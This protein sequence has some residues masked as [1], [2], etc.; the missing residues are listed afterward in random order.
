MKIGSWNTAALFAAVRTKSM[1]VDMVSD[2]IPIV[3][4]IST[5]RPQDL[6][7][8]VAAYPALAA[9]FPAGLQDARCEALCQR[10]YVNSFL[11]HLFTF[12]DEAASHGFQILYERK[13]VQKQYTRALRHEGFRGS[14][15]GVRAGARLGGGMPLRRLS[16][17]ARACAR[18][19]AAEAADGRSGG[20][21]GAEQDGSQ[22]RVYRWNE[23]GKEITTE[24][25]ES[26]FSLEGHFESNSSGGHKEYQDRVRA[27]HFRREGKSK[28]E[29]ASMLGRSDKFV[30][31]WWQKDEREIPRPWGVHEYLSKEMGQKTF[32]NR[33]G[34]VH[35]E[36]KSTA[37]WWRDVEIRRG[38]FKDPRVYEELLLQ[39][40]WKSN[41]AR[42]R[43]FATGASHVRYDKD[44][45]MRMQGNQGAK[46]R[47]GQSAAMDRCIQKFF[48]EYG[49]AERTSGISLN[50][51][52]D[53]HS[54]LGSHR[55]DCWT[56]LFSFGHERILTID[57]TPVLCQDGDLLIFGTQRHGVPLMPDIT[58]GRIT[59]PVFFYP[60]HL[61][62]QK[63]WQTLTDPED[64]RAS[65][66]LAR[67]ER[68]H[69]LGADA[70]EAALWGGPGRAAAV[71]QLAR[72]GFD[73]ALARQALHAHGFDPE[74]GALLGNYTLRG[75]RAPGTSSGAAGSQRSGRWGHARGAG[76]PEA[77]AGG[78]AGGG[79]ALAQEEHGVSEDEA[80]ALQMQLDEEGALGLDGALC[81]GGHADCGDDEDLAAALAA[82]MEEQD[83]A[84]GP[85]GAQAALLEAQFQA[86]EDQLRQEDA[87]RWHGH[88]DLMQ[89]GF[90]RE[91]LTL[92]SMDKV[93]CYS[94]G[95][96]RMPEK[97]FY[98]LLSMHAIR[99]LYDF[100]HCDHHGEVYTPCQ[101]YSVRALQSTCRA[102]GLKYKH[103][104][105]GRE[106][107]Y[108][109]LAHISS[110]EAQHALIELVW[111][112]KRGRTAFLGFEEDWRM[113]RRQVVA[114]EL[115]KVGHAVK[116][117]DSTGATE[118]HVLLGSFPDFIVQEEEK[119]RK[120]E[121]M[122]QAGELKRPEKSAVDR[123]SEAIASRLDRPAQA[124]DAMDELRAA[125]NQVEL[126]QVQRRLARVQRLADR[127]GVM[128]NK[129]LAGAPR[130]I[131][132]EAREQERWIAQK[133][134]EKAQQAPRAE[135]A[136]RAAA[137]DEPEQGE[138]AEAAA[139]ALIV[140]CSL[141][142]APA[143]WRVLQLGDG[144]CP[145][146]R[147]AE[148]G[149]GSAG[150]AR[151]GPPPA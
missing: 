77:R 37:S 53:G 87:E 131:L 34:E 21:G 110:D 144:A 124:V 118:D 4:T 60:D 68:E 93:S 112:A 122:R 65:R 40:D 44:G 132:E 50:L 135:K 109:V 101:R 38:Y 137:A 31:K 106:S 114:E 76:A 18:D 89:S 148:G 15:R 113:D 85:P 103:V 28:A 138:G 35:E 107:A 78:G 8:A 11:T 79:G 64:P 61:Q 23:F 10:W 51:Y 94:V 111:H 39:S 16:E 146:C 105:L 1:K 149:S 145:L 46:Y 143:P 5:F 91:V 139:E 75:G 6:A 115:A 7:A 66:T 134:A 88:G 86:Y 48:A 14:G 119:L 102:R 2:H 151:A 20:E 24:F 96:G 63:Q 73:P 140:E 12:Q 9:H 19:A 147:A 45:K 128:A 98:E 82:Q 83:R 26:H 136:Q 129:E 80:L 52:P 54:T 121:K 56:A 55:H 81:C 95:H 67:L 108:G 70:A 41:A 90:A 104:A 3:V 33:A 22:V 92:A 125:G 69:G 100:R 58:E 150:S 49:V 43:D 42:T 17:A 36:A 142:S 27:V 47:Q 25:D 126:E 29:I 116:H 141:C 13:D 133:K 72:A 59:V 84:G 62:M 127:K 120:L 30:A 71:E 74:A 32:N 99:T 117:I 123:S 130:W 57:K 97:S